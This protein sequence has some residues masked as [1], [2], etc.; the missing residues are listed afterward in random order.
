MQLYEL[1]YLISPELN[2]EEIKDFSQKID[3]LVSKTGKIAKSE[4]PRKITLAYPI[5]KKGEAFLATFEFQSLPQEA[6]NLKKELEKEKNILRFLLIK[7]RGVEKIKKRLRPAPT[8]V[9]AD[10]KEKPKP[11]KK[12]ELKEI[13]KKLEEVL[14]E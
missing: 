10:K 8:I 3:S 7:K 11:V 12:V 9:S 14:K 5:Q 2:E 13:E 6:E 4:S 1:T